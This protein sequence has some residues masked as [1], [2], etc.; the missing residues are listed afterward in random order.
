MPTPLDLTGQRFGRLVVVEP[1]PNVGTKTAWRCLCDCGTEA[2]VRTANLRGTDQGW[3]GTQSCGCLKSDTAAEA[4]RQN[5]LGAVAEPAAVATT[6]DEWL[7]TPPGVLY[8]RQ[9]P[10]LYVSAV[11]ARPSLYVTIAVLRPRAFTS[12]S[13][14]DL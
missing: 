5:R 9:P 6:G 13:V 2:I 14:V 8:W 3:H 11:P 4:M 12:M 7:P 10:K 1:A